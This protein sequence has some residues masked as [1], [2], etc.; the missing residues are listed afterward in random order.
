MSSGKVAVLLS[1]Y[2][3]EKYLDELL[4]SLKE[5]EWPDISLIV[6]DDQS[7]DKTLQVLKRNQSNNKNIFT[8]LPPGDHLGAAR[9]FLNLLSE[10]GDGFDF[11]AFS[12]QD[13]VWSS[14]K[15]SRAVN[16]LNS[17]SQDIPALYCSRLD[18]VDEDLHHLRLSRIPRRIGFGNA[19]VE[20]VAIGCSIVMNKIARKIILSG[21]PDNCRMHDWWCYLTISCFGR[22]VFDDFQESNIDCILPTRLV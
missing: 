13:D 20:N 22:V 12:D 6:R 8:I 4:L 10:A 17:V 19:I 3:G 2:N 5:Q 14:D 11:Y 7:A 15:I 16:K 1:T 21:L 9:S 18:Y